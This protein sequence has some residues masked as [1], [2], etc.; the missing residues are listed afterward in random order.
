ME[1]MQ[2]KKTAPVLEHRSG[3]A[4]QNPIEVNVSTTNEHYITWG[5]A[6]PYP[7]S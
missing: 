7:F 2:K 1:Q 5:L 4:K 3:Q 6:L